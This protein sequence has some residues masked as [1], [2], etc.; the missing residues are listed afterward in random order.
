MHHKMRDL[1][2][3]LYINECQCVQTFVMP[4]ISIFLAVLISGPHGAAIL[5]LRQSLQQYQPT[6]VLLL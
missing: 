1:Y 5:L 2:K 6:I 3:N 4:E